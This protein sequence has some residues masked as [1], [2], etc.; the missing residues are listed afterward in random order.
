MSDSVHD[1]PLCFPSPSPAGHFPS[2]AQLCLAV[3]RKHGMK[4]AMSMLLE[5][6]RE[7]DLMILTPLMGEKITPDSKTT[8]WWRE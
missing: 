6:A 7:T 3:F 2:I 1:A 4:S 5:A 8:L